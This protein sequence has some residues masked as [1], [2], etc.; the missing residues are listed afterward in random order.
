MRFDLPAARLGI[1]AIHPVKVGGKQRGFLAA[2]AGADFDD[3]VAR[4]GRVG[5]HKA[6]LDLLREFF[7]S[8]F[9]PG[10]FFLGHLRQ[11]GIRAV[12]F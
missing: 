10:D 9:E 7:L 1:A 3:G 5:R 12:R 8:R 4:I 2:G 11:F 6:E